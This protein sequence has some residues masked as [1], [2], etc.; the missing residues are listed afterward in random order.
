MKN[1]KLV[2]DLDATLYYAGDKIEKLCDEK[3]INFFAKKMKITDEEAERLVKQ[4]RSRYVYDVEALES[5]FPFSKFEFLEDIC[6]VDVSMLQSDSELNEILHKLPQDKYILTDS[7]YRHV[8][9]TLKV[10]HVDEQLFKGVF[11]AH[12]M[13]Y[14]FKYRPKSFEQFLQKYGLQSSECI[15]FEDSITNLRVAK[16]L[17]FITVL[18]R[19]EKIEDDKVD[20]WFSDIKSALKALFL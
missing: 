15:L 11:D 12:D 16:S 14:I 17:G 3:V 7:I 18:V 10:L 2:F 1:K 19:P 5:D 13:G 9:D 4:V 20:Y 8:K 6:D